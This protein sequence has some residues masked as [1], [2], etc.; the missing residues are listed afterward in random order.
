MDWR[1]VE[2]HEVSLD[3]AFTVIHNPPP[4]SQSY[5]GRSSRG[6][7]ETYHQLHD[8]R[9]KLLLRSYPPAFKNE[10]ERSRLLR[11]DNSKQCI[12]LME[13]RIKVRVI[14]N[15]VPITSKWLTIPASPP[16][17]RLSSPVYSPPPLPTNLFLYMTGCPRLH[18]WGCF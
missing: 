14:R 11:A 12:S 9:C 4:I 2:D 17:P 10:S 6:N 13:K 7:S 18:G 16:F 8:A 15:A 5:R 1:A 3:Q